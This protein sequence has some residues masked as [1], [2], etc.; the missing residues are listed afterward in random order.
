MMRVYWLSIICTTVIVTCG[1]SGPVKPIFEIRDPP[2]VW[3]AAPNQ[4]RIRF[5]GMLR[6]S[7]DLKPPRRPLAAIGDLFVG[8]AEPAPLYGPRSVVCTADGRRVWIADPGGR[9]LHVFNLEKRDYGKVYGAE[10]TPLLSP[11][12]LSLGPEGSIYVCDSERVAIYQLSDRDGSLLQALRVPAEL[13]RPA[14]VHY[15]AGSD[16]LFVVDVAAHDVKVLDRAGGLVTIFG[17]RGRAP[18]EFNFPS[19]IV[20]DERQLWI[21]DTGNHRVQAVT[22]DGKP[23]R[24]FGQSGDAY[25]DM[26]LPKGVALDAGGRIYVVDGRF[27]NVQIFD[28]SGSLLLFFGGEGHDPGEFWLPGGIFIEPGGRIWICDTYNRRVQVFD[29]IAESEG[30]RGE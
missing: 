28:Q 4:P 6:T 19:D 5:V 22:H 15:D 2:L 18:G 3:P 27:E 7:A 9:C 11:V 26:A 14:A 23:R 16:R 30:A 21:A 13:V 20:G 29:Y 17:R 1:C 25:G 8:P 10:D 12:S 24:A